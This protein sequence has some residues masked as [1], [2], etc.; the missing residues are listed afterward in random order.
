MKRPV[1]S[2][3]VVLVILHAKRMRRM[4]CPAL[5]YFSTLSHKR[6]VFR[7]GKKVTEQNAGFD[8]L[9]KLCLQTFLIYA[10]SETLF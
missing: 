5:P 10:F 6:H 4:S 8:L 3:S 7:G 2:V 1:H 9:Y